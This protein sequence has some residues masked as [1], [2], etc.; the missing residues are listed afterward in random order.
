MGQMES[1]PAKYHR[2]LLACI[3]FF[4]IVP[5]LYLVGAN[6][7][8][9]DNHMD[10]VDI[11]VSENRLPTRDEC[12]ECFQPK[13]YHL[14]TAAVVK[15]AGIESDAVRI[16]VAQALSCVAGLLTLLV[17]YRFLRERKLSEG[18]FL[19]A[20]GLVALNPRFI[21]INVQA[22]N[23]SFVIF[24]ATISIYWALKYFRTWRW[25]DLFLMTLFTFLA[26]WSKGSGITVLLVI[27]GAFVVKGVAAL[28]AQRRQQIKRL[29]AGAGIFVFVSLLVALPGQF[30]WNYCTYGS[31]FVI[32]VT[33]QP[34]PHFNEFSWYAGK[35]GIIT[36][37]SG[38]LTF[39]L[40]SLLRNPSGDDLRSGF[41]DVP[42]H[43]TSFWSHNYGQFYFN[44][45][46]AWP[47]TWATDSSAVR[48]IG[49]ASLLLGLVP[50]ALMVAGALM[51][52]W[53]AL[54]HLFKRNAAFFLD[55][56]D[57]ILTALGVAYVA[58]TAVYALQYRD[59]SVIKAIFLMP[60][61]LAFT[62]WFVVGYEAMRQ[63]LGSTV[64]KGAALL[65]ALLLVFFVLDTA[66]LMVQLPVNALPSEN[67][68]WAIEPLSRS[69][70][71]GG[72]LCSLVA[73]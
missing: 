41:D 42:R 11:I 20:F 63:R 64:T 21:G 28:F 53:A 29:A 3:L 35:P 19:L 49:R 45:Y 66:S 8:A 30:A 48:M 10:V 58:F 4:A 65:V 1:T 39:R 38:F 67:A 5:R 71:A 18:L 16:R 68:I 40:D 24:F 12:W 72:G 73:R 31:P 26:I 17:I 57:W 50:T 44:R 33:A 6:A 14:A 43:R 52:T 13:F 22:T 47:P 15:A 25:R 54:V 61:W 23:D 51:A 55:E 34:L 2:I 37:R 46:S 9:N 27:V 69:A 59:S 60:A 7:E 62:Y 56:N 36:I 70:T 32:N